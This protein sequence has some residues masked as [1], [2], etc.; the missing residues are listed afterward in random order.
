MS[1]QNW[2]E[3]NDDDQDG[4][5]GLRKQLQELGKKLAERDNVIAEL[6]KEQ[7]QR[8]VSD[9]LKGFNLANPEKVA[10]L[11]P[12]EV[13]GDA[14]KVKAW[15][16]EFKDVLGFAQAVEASAPVESEAAVDEP[17]SPS[18]PADQVTALQRFQ[19]AATAGSTA[20]DLEAQQAAQLASMAQA[21][22]GDFDQFVSLLR[23]ES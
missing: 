3:Q 6:Q 2:Y 23:G 15:V 8:T 13:A 11:I 14:D 19:N 7:R 20:P 10:K 22:G 17:A 18:L 21:A 5:S 1:N 4:P 9:T 12:S 16:A